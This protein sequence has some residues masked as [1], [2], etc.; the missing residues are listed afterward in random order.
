VSVALT[1]ETV[2]DET[3]TIFDPSASI[4]DPGAAFFDERG[5][6]V[7]VGATQV[8]DKAAPPVW[9]RA[10]EQIWRLV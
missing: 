4:L 8:R 2:V 9:P 3:D 5:A 10:P 7:E 1:I 6:F